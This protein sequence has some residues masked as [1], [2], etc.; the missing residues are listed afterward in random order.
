MNIE[1]LNNE[2]SKDGGYVKYNVNN[3]IITV[4]I[5]KVIPQYEKHE[6]KNIFLGTKEKIELEFE[7][8][9]NLDEF[10]I[11]HPKISKNTLVELEKDAEFG[12][13]Q[14][15]NDNF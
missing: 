5:S 15:A 7:D 14:W 10:L 3:N 12:Y 11:H 1:L 13:S 8:C 4:R 2:F 9:K 6:D